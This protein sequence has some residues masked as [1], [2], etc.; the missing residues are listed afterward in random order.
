MNAES[1]PPLMNAGGSPSG[2]GRQASVGSSPSRLCRPMQ[3]LSA[4]TFASVSCTW[5]K[6][7]TIG[8]A[9]ASPAPVSRKIGT[10]RMSAA[11]LHAPS[12][13]GGVEL[14]RRDLE[15]AGRH[16]GEAV[17][18]ERVARG[19]GAAGAQ[20][21]GRRVELEQPGKGP[22][23][24]QVAHGQ[25]HREAL[26]DEAGDIADREHVGLRDR[27]LRHPQTELGRALIV[28]DGNAVGRDSRADRVRRRAV[29]GAPPP[30]PL[31][32]SSSSRRRRRP[33]TP[34][35]PPRPSARTTPEYANNTSENR[36]SRL[37]WCRKVRSIGGAKC[38]D[39]AV[40]VT[41]HRVAIAD[42]HAS[43]RDERDALRSSG[44]TPSD[45]RSGRRAG[46]RRGARAASESWSTPCRPACAASGAD[47]LVV[48]DGHLHHAIAA[49]RREEQRVDG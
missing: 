42:A 34:P 26:G 49:L 8:S 29:A 19:H 20:L 45:A 25:I 47:P 12:V 14:G 33:R 11:P 43:A 27:Q 2:P 36:I 15:L 3:L 44:V 23:A 28:V 24:I 21:A 6:G 32:S 4:D 38:D 16:V 41:P 9:A 7:R 46:R 13:S 1:L 10:F 35:P 30:V 37:L 39:H 17:A 31:L 22:G 5:C 18:R 48:V 40:E